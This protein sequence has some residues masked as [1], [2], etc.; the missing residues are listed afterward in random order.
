[1]EALSRRTLPLAPALAGDGKTFY[2]ET[3]GCQMNVHDSE[4]VAGVLM[5]R[6]YRPVDSHQDADIILYNTCSI[7]EKAA[8]KVFSRLGTFRKAGSAERKIIGVLGCVAQQEGERFFE[9]APQVSLVCG[10]ASYP[11]LQR[12]AWLGRFQRCSPRHRWFRSC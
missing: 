6:G 12:K 11:Q 7:R 1:M 9:R 10:S 5:A 8:Q 3:F 2:I 4:K